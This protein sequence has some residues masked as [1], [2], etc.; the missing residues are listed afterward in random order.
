MKTG[1]IFVKPV[2]GLS[3]KPF[4]LKTSKA[5]IKSLFFTLCVIATFG[6]GNALFFIAVPFI[7]VYFF[8]DWK[9]SKSEEVILLNDSIDAYN[10]S[11]FEKSE[12][13]VRKVLEKDSTN[14]KA[15]I[16]LALICYEKE[17]F[18]EAVRLLEMV[19]KNIIKNDLDLQL[20]LA[21]AYFN[22][23]NYDKS[24]EMYS[25]LLRVFPSSEYIKKEIEELNKIKQ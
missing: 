10:E 6:L 9:K 21:K 14:M 2:E 7:L 15:I 16:I 24:K 11:K 4:Y 25:R 5:K 23:E 17:D 20:K 12:E 19:P 22:T 3:P 8:L 13:K 18:K 1:S